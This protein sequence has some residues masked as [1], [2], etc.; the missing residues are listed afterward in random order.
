MLH[1]ISQPAILRINGIAPCETVMKKRSQFKQVYHKLES[2]FNL[3]KSRISNA[4]T[5]E[6]GEKSI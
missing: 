3:N 4:P 2:H 6:V 5:E 1:L